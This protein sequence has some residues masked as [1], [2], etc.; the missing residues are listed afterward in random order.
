MTTIESTSSPTN[1]NSTKSTRKPALPP[2]PK[3]NNTT[4]SNH[5]HVSLE[6]DDNNLNNFLYKQNYNS[7]VNSLKQ[8]LNHHHTHLSSFSS[9][10]SSSSSSNTTNTISLL[11]EIY[12]EIEDKQI[13][14]TLLSNYASSTSS[15]SSTSCSSCASSSSNQDDLILTSKNNSPI[16]TN[17]AIVESPP[18][19]PSVPPPPLLSPIYNTPNPLINCNHNN[20]NDESPI[21]AQIKTNDLS[22]EQ[23]IE[24][25]IRNKLNSEFLLS[26]K[27]N[28]NDETILNEKNT[29]KDLNNHLKLDEPHDFDI[30][31]DFDEEEN[32]EDE[33][34]YLEP[35]HVNNIMIQAH[36]KHYPLSLE[37]NTSNISNNS[38]KEPKTPNFYK[39][40]KQ[41][42]LKNLL[43][44]NNSSSA[45]NDSLT[46]S[47]NMSGSRF[48]SNLASKTT[49]LL[50]KSH[51][52]LNSLSLTS[53]PTTS[54]NS[55]QLELTSPNNSRLKMSAYSPSRL[56]NYIFT[57]P[58]PKSNSKED[59]SSSSLSTNEPNNNNN[60][61]NN[62][63]TNSTHQRLNNLFK[64]SG[65]KLTST[66]RL[67]KH[68]SQS[69]HNHYNNTDKNLSTLVDSFNN[70]NNNNINNQSSKDN[71]NNNSHIIIS[72][73]RLI[74]QT[75]DLNKQCL[76][77]I[78]NEIS[79]DEI[80]NQN[81]N[82]H[83]QVETC[84][85]TSFSSMSHQSNYA[86]STNI[87]EDEN[88]NDNY[89]K[90]RNIYYRF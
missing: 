12:A 90:F 24:L 2:K 17:V 25:E 87:Y 78:K 86:V 45:A 60:N 79:Q 23:E 69:S 48:L 44:L 49:N 10:S 65:Q 20:D 81:Q 88:G 63:I 19:L 47:S 53:T 67:I 5:N 1:T 38:N 31:S 39:K 83:Q 50:S 73:P 16:L 43:L 4:Q 15:N 14:S 13:K 41:L 58:I 80:S 62:S 26:S 33:T 70:N 32:L 75:F 77:E 51:S 54:N 52:K 76:I 74:S 7:I 9:S 71:N 18:P 68:R 36:K 11:D 21:I 34:E 85:L 89:L 6:L 66:L 42:K 37:I 55:N 28:N 82:Q 64:S 30:D 29:S 72:Q 40:R 57:S 84:S 8:K 22:L 59:V 27:S 46:G 61:S 56:K 3:L 35:V